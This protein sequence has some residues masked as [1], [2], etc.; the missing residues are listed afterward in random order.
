M[1]IRGTDILDCPLFYALFYALFN[2]KFNGT[3]RNVRPP[4]SGHPLLEKA[5]PEADALVLGQSAARLASMIGLFGPAV[6]Q[7]VIAFFASH[8]TIQ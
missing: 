1:G 3:D 8:R 5:E 7:G 4:S 6:N 2:A